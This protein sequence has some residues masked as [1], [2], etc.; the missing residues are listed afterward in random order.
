MLYSVTDIAGLNRRSRR[1][2]SNAAHQIVGA[3]RFGT[4]AQEN[5]LI[6]R[7]IGEKMNTCA[8]EVRFV[9]PEGGVSALDAPGQP[10]WDPLALAAFVQALEDTLQQTN[11]RRLIKTPYHINDPRFAQVIAE[12]FQQITNTPDDFYSHC[13]MGERLFSQQ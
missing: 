2:L 6:G 8:G 3:M 11:R 5:S 12:Q 4:T 13:P 7:W 10:F 1:G 9:I